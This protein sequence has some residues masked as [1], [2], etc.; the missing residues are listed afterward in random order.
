[1]PY[2]INFQIIF[3]ECIGQTLC[4][5]KRKAKALARDGVDG[6]GGIA[7]QDELPTRD[8]PQGSLDGKG[9]P[10]GSLRLACGRGVDGDEEKATKP[11]RTAVLIPRQHYDTNLGGTY[12]GNEHLASV[13]PIHLNTIGP[14]LSLE[15][16]TVPE[17][18]LPPRKIVDASPK[19]NCRFLP[20]G[21]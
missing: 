9:S 6:A 5:P 19:A 3:H 18:N 8:T 1:M 13:A 21:S 4:L 7:D 10:R 14:G 17:A 15:V 20:I 12:R 16:A 11:C 2:A